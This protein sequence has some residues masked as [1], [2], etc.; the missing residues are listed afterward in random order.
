M[1]VDTGRKIFRVQVKSAALLDGDNAIIISCRSTHVNCSS[2]KNVYYTSDD[3]DYFATFY[4]G[5]CYLIPVFECASS[6]TLRFS[7]PKNGQTKGVSF[8]KD[9]ILAKQLD[10]IDNANI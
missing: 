2:V 7:S 8:A 6:K 5:E 10:L 4:D 1:I 9:Y 3:T